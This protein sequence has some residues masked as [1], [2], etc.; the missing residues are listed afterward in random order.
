MKQPKRKMLKT[1]LFTKWNF[2]RNC[3]RNQQFVNSTRINLK[4][5]IRQLEQIGKVVKSRSSVLFWKWHQDKFDRVNAFEWV[6][7][8]DLAEIDNPIFQIYLTEE[9]ADFI[10]I[11]LNKK[12]YIN[13]TKNVPESNLKDILIDQNIVSILI[14]PLFDKDTF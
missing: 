2:N 10:Q 12:P 8:T 4:Y 11:I 13:L 6:S 3:K 9:F 7:E 1:K 5:S 14:I